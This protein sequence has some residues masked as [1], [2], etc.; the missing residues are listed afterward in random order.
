MSTSEVAK[1]NEDWFKEQLVLKRL[2]QRKLARHLGLDPSAIT[3]TLK[4][5]RRMQMDEAANIAVFLGVPVEEVLKNAG[6]T[7]GKPISNPVRIVGS[8]SYANRIELIDTDDVVES[9]PMMPAE[10]VAL[11]VGDPDSLLYGSLLFYKPES[12]INPDAIG[13]LSIVKLR[14]GKSILARIDRGIRPG[15]YNLRLNSSII[16][17]N[18]PLSKKTAFLSNMKRAFSVELPDGE[19]ILADNPPDGLLKDVQLV[20]ASPVLT[21]QP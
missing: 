5:K 18:F 21:I 3:L 9:P 17:P 19:T 12:E 6:L 10:T 2:S 20:T 15:F 8:V 11:T 7:L 1:V 13:R 16:P 4:G 14:S